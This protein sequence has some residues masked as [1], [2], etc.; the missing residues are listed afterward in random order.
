MYLGLANFLRLHVFMSLGYI[1]TVCIINWLG[2]IQ[3]N[4]IPKTSEYYS[5][6]S[7]T[8]FCFQIA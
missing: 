6:G 5:V 1:W 3:S 2:H 8:N 7:S 4:S